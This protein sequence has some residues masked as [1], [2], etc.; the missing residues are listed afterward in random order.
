MQPFRHLLKPGSH[1]EWT[2]ELDHLF[3]ESKSVIIHEIQKGV[4]I[5]DKTR[6]TC[7]AT[8]WKSRYA[9]VEG[10]ALAAVDALDKASHFVL[11]CSDLILAVDHKSLLKMFADR[12][13]EDIPNPRLRNLKEKSLRYRFRTMHVPGV[14]HVAADAVSRRPV[15]EPTSM[16]LPD[17][18]AT[19]LNP[20]S[21]NLPDLPHSFLAAIRT[22]KRDTAKI[23]DVSTTPAAEMIKSVT[24]DDVRLATS[25]DPSM[26]KLLDI[27]AD[28]FPD[29]HKDLLPDLRPYHR[30]RDDL[31]SFDGVAF[32][33]DRVI[34][35]QSLHYRVLQALH[36]AHQGVF[37]MCSSAESYFF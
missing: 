3:E 21:S 37:Q 7:L 33:N 10:E 26:T 34:I 28:G 14:R 30:F 25:S 16:M 32:Y 27:I 20:A 17:D 19:I 15:G 8:D 5:F 35:P 36:S 11:G 12:S 23:C 24:W 13:L 2:K 31:T 18:I 6:P 4:E 22:Q 29:S 1:F 9:S